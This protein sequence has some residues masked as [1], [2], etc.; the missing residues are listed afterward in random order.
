MICLYKLTTHFGNLFENGNNEFLLCCNFIKSIA[1]Y[2]D[3][4]YNNI[5]E[6]LS[7]IE[8]PTIVTVQSV[9]QLIFNSLDILYFI[10]INNNE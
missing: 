4:F 2:S 9:N 5:P 1:L 3:D 7:D 6:W 8:T 10:N